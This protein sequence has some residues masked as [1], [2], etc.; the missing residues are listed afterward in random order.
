MNNF[1]ETDKNLFF[2][3]L[4]DAYGDKAD[5]V[6]RTNAEILEWID[7]NYGITEISHK[8]M[9]FMGYSSLKCFRD[10]FNINEKD[11][12]K[13]Y[14]LSDN[15]NTAYYYFECNR[16]FT[17]KLRQEILKEHNKVLPERFCVYVF[18]VPNQDLLCSNSNLLESKFEILKGIDAYEIKNKTNKYCNYLNNFYC[19]YRMI[20]SLSDKFF[21]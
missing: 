2:C 12:I 14:L 16:D 9:D 15:N 8:D 19:Y 6:T 21:D 3:E 5:G 18:Y 11:E 1:H 13:I 7:D 4:I 17:D 10:N 20:E